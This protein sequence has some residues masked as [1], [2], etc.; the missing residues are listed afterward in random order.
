M[1]PQPLGD[2]APTK[3]PRSSPLPTLTQG[4]PTRTPLASCATANEG[5]LIEDG[6]DGVEEHVG[7]DEEDEGADGDEGEEELE[8]ERCQ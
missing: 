5:D 3:T 6:A 7:E 1:P 2:A 4:G 8:R